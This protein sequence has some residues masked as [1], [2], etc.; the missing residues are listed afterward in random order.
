MKL[1]IKNIGLLIALP[2]ILAS[3][4]KDKQL[5]YNE[6]PSIYVYDRVDSTVFTFATVPVNV[7]KDT[8]NVE[9]R[10]IGT[11]AAQDRTIKLEP[12][13]GATAKPGY[14]YSVGPAVVK[15]NEYS[16]IVPIYVYRKVGLKDSTVT[17]ILDIKENE[18]FKL[19]YLGRL[20]YKLSISDILSKPTIWD[21]AW[22]P[23]FG[24]YSQVKFRFL[25]EATG[26][27]EW[28]SFPF[29]ADSRFMSQRAKNALLVYNQQFGDLFDENN[30]RVVFP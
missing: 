4:A 30:E 16:A 8:I 29:P 11:A 15:A 7:V 2:V 5:M 6:Q 21:S 27:T 24:S 9:Y 22:A 3:C 12:R 19:G 20:R 18:D 28:N 1:S 25:L 10:I 26:R 23:Y 13:A 17:V 14:H